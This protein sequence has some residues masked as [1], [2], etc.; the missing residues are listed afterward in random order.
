MLNLGLCFKDGDGVEMS[1]EKAVEWWKRAAELG[2]AE[3]MLLFAWCLHA[4]FGTEKNLVQ[5]VDWYRRAADLGALISTLNLACCLLTGRGVERD[6]AAGRD[7]LTQL[8]ASSVADDAWRSVYERCFS[9]SEWTPLDDCADELRAFAELKNDDD[10][11][12]L[13][14]MQFAARSQQPQVSS[15]TAADLSLLNR[16]AEL[17]GGAAASDDDAAVLANATPL[18]VPGRQVPLELFGAVK[19]VVDAR[20]EQLAD[21]SVLTLARLIAT[22]DGAAMSLEFAD[23]RA[24]NSV[25]ACVYG[26]AYAHCL[27]AR[28]TLPGDLTSETALEATLLWMC[29]A[30][31]LAFFGGVPA[32][33]EEEQAAMA[34]MERRVDDRVR[35]EP[36][37]RNKCADA[38]F[39]LL[40]A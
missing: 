5:A 27:A 14:S 8:C 24:R 12:W 22:L 4:G 26:A 10:A 17:V 36:Q 20:V 39:L 29:L 21:K 34:A 37:L 15:C 23:E 7:L 28:S 38:S 2:N 31:Q 18:L 6:E 19:R 40:L 33:R 11:K 35:G 1:A 9:G 16:I 32:S 30:Q 3:A 13:L 25:R